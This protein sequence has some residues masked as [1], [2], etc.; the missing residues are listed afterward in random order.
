MRLVDAEWQKSSQQDSWQL[1]SCSCECQSEEHERVSVASGS[2]QAGVEVGVNSKS[3]RQ[4]K[5]AKWK[6]LNVLF[7]SDAGII[8]KLMTTLLPPEEA[9]DPPAL[10]K[11]ANRRGGSNQH[12]SLCTRS[13]QRS[14]RLS[15][16]D[17]AKVSKRDAERC[18]G[19]TLR[20]EI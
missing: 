5:Y 14:S 9:G 16:A 8:K 13:G 4:V 2:K 17:M 12:R 10:A 11:L 20:T 3:S 6:D 18:S 19:D 7:K 1:E 15:Q